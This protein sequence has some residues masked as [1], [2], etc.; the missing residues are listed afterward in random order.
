MRPS[1]RDTNIDVIH[2]HGSTDQ[3]VAADVLAFHGISKEEIWANMPATCTA[4]LEH[5]AGA[6]DNAAAGL[7]L[8]PGVERLL[9]TLAAGTKSLSADVYIPASSSSHLDAVSAASVSLAYICSLY[10]TQADYSWRFHNLIGTRPH[11]HSL[12]VLALYGQHVCMLRRH[13]RWKPCHIRL[14]NILNALQVC[15]PSNCSRP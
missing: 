4:M 12:E 9:Q 5:A 2:H 15:P 8:L 14:Y 13:H 1:E 3:L 10:P 11:S 7:E 6:E